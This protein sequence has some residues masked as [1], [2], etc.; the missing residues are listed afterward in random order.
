MLEMIPPYSA[1]SAHFVNEITFDADDFEDFSAGGSDV[2]DVIGE[3]VG[4]GPDPGVHGYLGQPLIHRRFDEKG[5]RVDIVDCL[6]L[7][8]VA[9]HEV[10]SGLVK[11]LAVAGAL[12]GASLVPDRQPVGH[13]RGLAFEIAL[14]KSKD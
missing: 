7:Q 2:H 14:W 11:F 5:S 6:V 9:L 3:V 8:T 12:P 13:S 4:R 10:E 1:I